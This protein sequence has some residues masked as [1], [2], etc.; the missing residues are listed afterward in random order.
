MHVLRAENETA[1]IA[2][3]RRKEAD[4][5][6]LAAEMTM[7]VSDAVRRE[8]LG[9]ESRRWNPYEPQV[10]MTIPGWVGQEERA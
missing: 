2:N 1:V 5:A 4:A 6:R 7:R 8:V 9:Q 10:E 3:Y